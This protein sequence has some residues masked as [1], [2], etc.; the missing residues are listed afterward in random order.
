MDAAGRPLAPEAKVACRGTEGTQS[1]HRALSTV[2]LLA[3]GAPQGMKLVDI[4]DRLGLHHSTAHR[5]LA[6]L[7]Q[8]GVVERVGDTKRY[9]I[10]SELVW[11]SLGAS[12]RFPI[13][14]AAAP[15]LDRLSEQVG[16]AIFLTV[17]SGND[18]VCA[19]RRI[20]AFPIQVLSIAIGSRRPL[21]V[22]QGGRVILA[23]LP[24]ETANRVIAANADR[25]A[26]YGCDAELLARN[27]MTARSAGY[28]CSDGV[29]VKET[30]VLA[31]PVM[32]ANGMPVAAISVIA[33]RR[34]L[35]AA[36]LPAV[37]AAL[38]AA[39]REISRNLPLTAADRTRRRPTALW[40]TPAP[41]DGG[42]DSG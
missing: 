17:Q 29:T 3:T 36:R 28:I 24:A 42:P 6:A 27:M 40:R 20:G 25:F 37:L 19:D 1:I 2:R 33:V 16:D 4:A 35:P 18:S 39:A 9:T 32:A 21:G 31:V 8:E 15:A 23:F 22:S 12:S 41:H 10:G 30:R 34:R 13:A 11:L 14:A 7:E 38:Q 5:I 26:Q